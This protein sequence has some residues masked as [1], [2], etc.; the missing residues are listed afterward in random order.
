M[1][2]DIPKNIISKNLDKKDSDVVKD[3]LVND[4]DFEKS[5]KEIET[6]ESKEELKDPQENEDGDVITP[7]DLI[8]KAIKDPGVKPIFTR[9]RR[10][11]FFH[12]QSRLPRI[13]KE[14]NPS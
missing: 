14:N 4:K 3:E 5:E 8:E 1:G 13:T 11:L 9:S 6:S 12:N 2:K 7:N 10:N